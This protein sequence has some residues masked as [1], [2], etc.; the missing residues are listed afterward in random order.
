MAS[1]AAWFDRFVGTGAATPAADSAGGNGGGRRHTA[2]DSADDGAGGRRGF[3]PLPNEDV[4]LWVKRI[5]NSRVLR[6]SD[7]VARQEYWRFARVA[8]VA[9]ILVVGVLLPNAYGLLAGYQISALNLERD[10]MIDERKGLEAAEARL[11]S[12][13]RLAE[14]ARMQEFVDPAPENLLYLPPVNDKSLALNVGK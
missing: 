2:T 9:V 4:C 7:P 5:D 11:L 8:A 1:Q 6:K 12:P 10:R 3:R 14:L 13:E